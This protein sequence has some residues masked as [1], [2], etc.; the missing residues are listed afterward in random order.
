LHPAGKDRGH[1]QT[2]THRPGHVSDPS[3]DREDP[4]GRFCKWD[5]RHRWSFCGTDLRKATTLFYV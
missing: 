3:M 4:D 2:E 1:H 5:E